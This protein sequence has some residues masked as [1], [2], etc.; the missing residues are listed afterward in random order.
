MGW[1]II[2][3]IQKKYPTK[4][5]KE[6]ALAAM[7]DE[8]IDRLIGAAGTVQT[9]MFYARFKKNKKNHNDMAEPEGN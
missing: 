8:E 3:E 2:D 1:E 5:E 9:K 7:S 4:E 6:T